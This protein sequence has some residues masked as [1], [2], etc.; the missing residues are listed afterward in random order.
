[1]ELG[2]QVGLVE[3]LAEDRLGLEGEVG[4]RR[5]GLF[6]QDGERGRPGIDGAELQVGFQVHGAQSA[7]A[8]AAV[9]VVVV[10]AARRKVREKNLSGRRGR[11]DPEG[12]K[13]REEGGR[14]IGVG[15]SSEAFG[16]IRYVGTIQLQA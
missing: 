3:R 13:G 10:V 6:R 2:G 11:A 7:V 4:Q 15:S 8:S 14:G 1:M 12:A 9:A 5:M 16:Q